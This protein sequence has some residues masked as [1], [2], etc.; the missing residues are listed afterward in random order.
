M[1][2]E[3]FSFFLF[4]IFS[5]ISDFADTTNPSR[6]A[7]I[8]YTGSFCACVFVFLF[9]LLLHHKCLSITS[10]SFLCRTSHFSSTNSQF[11]C[12]FGFYECFSVIR[13]CQHGIRTPFWIWLLFISHKKDIIF[14]GHA[15]ILPSIWTHLHV[16]L[17]THTHKFSNSPSTSVA[18]SISSNF[19]CF[20]VNDATM[21]ACVLIKW[22][23]EYLILF[24]LKFQFGFAFASDAIQI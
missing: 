12:V 17:R 7:N 23:V 13:A 21:Y 24:S 1:K 6:E 18:I 9:V 15:N 14:A 5:F 3:S 22:A 20:Q 19:P 10:M 2:A 11:S 8:F 16:W 4:L